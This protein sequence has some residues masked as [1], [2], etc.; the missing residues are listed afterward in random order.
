MQKQ[1]TLLFSPEV[2]PDLEH[3]SQIR[4][5]AFEWLDAHHPGDV[6]FTTGNVLHM[7]G[8]SGR[9]WLITRLRA[10]GIGNEELFGKPATADALTVLF[11]RSRGVKFREAVDAVV[12]GKEGPRTTPELKYG[13]VWNRLIVAA[14]ERLR[15]RVPPRLLGSAVFS[16]LRDPK[17][18]PN[19]LIIVKRRGKGAD[20][21]ASDK[22]RPVSHDYVY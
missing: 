22:A 3:A 15:R 6:S 17:D 14:L 21:I 4:E 11:L 9:R 1:N 5:E 10:R 12:G 13:G 18:H 7:A 16:L 20:V 19:C 8:E 2:P